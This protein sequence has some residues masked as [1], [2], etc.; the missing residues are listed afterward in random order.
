MVSFSLTTHVYSHPPNRHLLLPAPPSHLAS[1]LLLNLNSPSLRTMALLLLLTSIPTSVGVSLLRAWTKL[2]RSGTSKTR[3]LKVFLAVR[4][5]SILPPHETLVLVESSL[6]DGH[7]IPRHHL[8]LRLPVARQLCKCGTWP[9]TPEQERRSVRGSGDM[10]GSWVRSRRVAVSW[11]LTE[12]KRK[13]QREKS[14]CP[15]N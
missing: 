6:P 7:L 11:L 3:N 5:K 2:S 14:R 10:D 13:N 8:Q 4:G 12:V 1:L 9:P 15:R